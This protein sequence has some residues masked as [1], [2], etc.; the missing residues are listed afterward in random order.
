M[1]TIKTIYKGNLATSTE[2]P[3]SE[4]PILTKAKPFGPTDLLTA[5]LSSCIATYI[6]FEA[7]KNNF[8]TPNIVVEINKTM[9][10]N[11]TKVVAFNTVINF[12]KEYSQE[13]KTVIEKAAQTCPVGNSLASDI[14]RTYQFNY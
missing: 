1:A 7:Q 3:M 9:N 4:Y 6:D 8:E 12:K 11:G 10:A 13:Q 5:S 14:S 2:Y